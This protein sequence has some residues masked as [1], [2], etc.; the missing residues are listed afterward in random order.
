MINIY[1]LSDPRTNEIR[2]IGKTSRTLNQRLTNHISDARVKRYKNH[3]CNWIQSLL[4]LDLFPKIELLDSIESTD[5]WEWLE[6]YWIAQ[7]R[8]WGFRLTNLTNGGDGNK[9]QVF[10]AESIEKR[11]AANRGQKRTDEFKERHSKLLKGIP[12]SD[13][14]KA[15]IR[16]VVVKNQG[17]KVVQLDLKTLE[18]IKE[19]ECIIDPAR[20]YSVDSSSLMRCCQ[21]KFK[22]SA[23]YKWMYLE[24]YNEFKDMT[25]TSGNTG[26]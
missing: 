12:K 6:S 17:R 22:K 2:Y 24:D 15:N 19:W 5:D 20:F 13:T 4:K 16:A 7:F 3:N 21:G 25:H 8:A 9:G 11:A 23:G 1:T 26:E 18:F 10:S 14:A